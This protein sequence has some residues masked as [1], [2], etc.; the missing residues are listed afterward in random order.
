MRKRWLLLIPLALLVAVTIVLAVQ[1][2]I[3]DADN[4]NTTWRTQDNIACDTADCHLSIDEGTSCDDD[5]TFITSDNSPIS[6]ELTQYTISDPGGTPDTGT[7]TLTARHRK[8][9]S[10]GRDIEVQYRVCEG[11]TLGTCTTERMAYS[12][13]S[14][15]AI[16]ETYA[17]IPPCSFDS[18]PSN[19]D[20][21]QVWVNAIETGSGGVRR[22]RVTC[23]NIGV[24]DAS[25]GG[26]TRRVF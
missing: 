21:L 11:T 6:G 3:P 8:N 9:T 25:G 16:S 10:A 18:E 5:T 1:D 14:F 19:Y 26:R 24:P 15:T 2:L 17:T 22:A 7:S 20:N 23:I 4:G 13:C 12:S